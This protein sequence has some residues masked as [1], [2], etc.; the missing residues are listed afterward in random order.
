[1]IGLSFGVLAAPA[2]LLAQG[3]PAPA[4][5]IQPASTDAKPHEGFVARQEKKEEAID[6]QQYRHSAT[7]LWVSKTLHTDL[8]TTA[9]GFE[10]INFGILV[11]AIAIPLIKIVP[12]IL[13]KRTAKLGF[14]LEVAK[15]MTEDANRRL[16]EVE[17]RLSGLDAE[18]DSIRKQV[19]ADIK[20]DEVRIKSSIEEESAR[21][22]AAAEQEIVMAGVQAQRGL[23]QF[24]ADLAVDRAL[25]QLT[26]N[27]ETDRALIAEFAH[28][29]TGKHG[30][31]GQN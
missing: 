25:S 24:A 28:D 2:A 31:R 10:Y 29:V 19:E 5:E 15:S 13:K 1:M 17:T 12:R 18:I 11:L 22:V 14:D 9:K 3:D 7:V 16:S 4:S 27:A 30:K 6:I 23:R 20:N 26:L 8:E 21:I